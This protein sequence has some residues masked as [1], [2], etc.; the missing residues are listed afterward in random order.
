MRLAGHHHD[1]CSHAGRPQLF[2]KRQAIF[3][4]HYYV[5]K[6]EIEILSLGQFERPVCIVADSRFVAGETEGA[7]QCGQ[8]VGL[9]VDN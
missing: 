4:G 6:D 3:G 7:R 2:E 8:R 5:R 9:V 1:G